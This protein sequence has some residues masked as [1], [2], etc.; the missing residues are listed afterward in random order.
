MFTS[1]AI[2]NV[3]TNNERIKAKIDVFFINF[4]LYLIIYLSHIVQLIIIINDNDNQYQYVA[5]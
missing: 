1:F 3:D 2:V 5:G 4:P